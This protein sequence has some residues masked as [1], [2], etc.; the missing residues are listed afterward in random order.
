[1]CPPPSVSTLAFE[2]RP[3]PPFNDINI[4]SI[5]RMHNFVNLIF[6][7]FDNEMKTQRRLLGFTVRIL[8]IVWQMAH[9]VEQP[10]RPALLRAAGHTI[11][12]I[13]ALKLTSGLPK[14]PSIPSLWWCFYS[15]LL[16]RLM[17]C[18]VGKKNKNKNFRM[19]EPPACTV[20][21]YALSCFPLRNKATG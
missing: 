12:V 19:F 4:M 6:F 17:L 2:T 13:F 14:F 3:L 15:V 18:F 8:V 1:M 7:H 10:H 11:L 16:D 20:L 9:T 5:G 21:G